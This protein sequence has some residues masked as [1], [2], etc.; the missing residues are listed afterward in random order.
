MARV[1]LGLGSNINPLENLRIG[2]RELRARYGELRLSAIYESAAV[3]FEGADE[4]TEGD[5]RARNA[6]RLAVGVI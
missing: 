5:C 3:G 4:S 1:Y 6:C 2:I